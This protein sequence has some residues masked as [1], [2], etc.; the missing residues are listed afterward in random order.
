MV[1]SFMLSKNHVEN[2]QTLPKNYQ[3]YHLWPAQDS[4]PWRDESRNFAH[5]EVS[6]EDLVHNLQLIIIS[7]E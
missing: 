1:P 2:N 5:W 4:H 6:P 7:C 3:H